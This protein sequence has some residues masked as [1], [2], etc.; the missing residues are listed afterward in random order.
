[1]DQDLSARA[2]ESQSR[3]PA[4]AARCAGDEGGLVNG[5]GHAKI[6]RADRFAET[7]ASKAPTASLCCSFEGKYTQDHEMKLRQARRF[8]SSRHGSFRSNLAGTKRSPSLL[9]MRGAG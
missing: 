4:D 6:F 3:R 5:V 1:M 2:G 9:T 8:R 7:M